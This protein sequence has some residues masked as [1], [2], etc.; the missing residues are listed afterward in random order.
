M[1][2]LWE[3]VTIYNYVLAHGY[4]ENGKT[5]L[6][7]R[8]DLGICKFQLPNPQAALKIAP[9]ADRIRFIKTFQP[10]SK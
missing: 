8:A 2:R 7:F 10:V 6:T 1:I 4:I 5:Y 3:C 9:T